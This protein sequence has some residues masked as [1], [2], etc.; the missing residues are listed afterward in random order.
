MTAS[1]VSRDDYHYARIAYN[2]YCEA[3]EWKSVIG[4]PLPL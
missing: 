3:R 1:I 2:A 4:Q